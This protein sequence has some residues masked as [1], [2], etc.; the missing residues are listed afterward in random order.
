MFPSDQ[1]TLKGFCTSYRLDRNSKGGGILLYF[2][3]DIKSR[4]LN[5]GSTCNI[6]TISVANNLWK[7]K[8]LLTCC[9]TPHKSLYSSYLNYLNNVVEKYSKSDENLVFREGF[10]V[11]MDNKFMINF[12]EQN[13]LSSLIDKPTCYKNFNRSTYIDLIFT[14]KPILSNNLPQLQKF[15]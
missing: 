12:W 1:F 13:D 7:T 3:E 8:W 2:R 10:N 14:N 11:S 15:W 4:L 9:Y 6:K 5:S